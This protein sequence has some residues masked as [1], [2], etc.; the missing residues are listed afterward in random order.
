MT[1]MNEWDTPTVYMVLALMFA[2]TLILL[3]YALLY[4]SIVDLLCVG[5][6]YRDD[7]PLLVQSTICALIGLV[8]GLVVGWI[9]KLDT[10]RKGVR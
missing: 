5:T 6:R 7:I 9:W 1:R 10:R 2:I 8:L 4:V 3:K